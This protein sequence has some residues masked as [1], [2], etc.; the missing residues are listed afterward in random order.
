MSR[1][2]A[3]DIHTEITDEIIAAIEAG[4]GGFTVPWRCPAVASGPP[5]NA[6]TGRPYSGVNMLL[7][8]CVT[9]R[10]GHPEPLWA[11]YR[12][13]HE[14]GRQVARGER[15]TRCVLCRPIGPDAEEAESTAAD[16]GDPADA[17]RRGRPT[18]RPE[19]RPVYLRRFRVFNIAQT[20]DY[21]PPDAADLPAEDAILPVRRAE[22]LIGAVGAQ[23]RIGGTRACY[24]PA[25]DIIRMPDRARFEGP[26]AAA[27]WYATLLHEL[28]HFSG[29]RLGRAD[30]APGTDAYAFEELVADIG[31]A[32]LM[33]R[34]GIA[35]RPL[36]GH[37]DYVAGWLKALKDD[38]RLIF[39][40]AAAAGRAADWLM[41][42]A[43]ETDIG[44]DTGAD[45][46][47]GGQAA[48]TGA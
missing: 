44:A 1:T 34:L 18:E 48:L 29:P 38:R 16:E 2:G 30:G 3:S 10:S 21:T 22:R 27:D 33:A 25:T 28:L 36:P 20:A 26:D 17:V 32:F 23:I 4:A 12:Q 19:G 6:V 46:G 11:T 31:S 8:M 13:W 47:A 42:H 15:G 35:P 37:A 24:E 5:R 40:A 14:A 7:L 45:D 9:M 39:R 41:A 43:P